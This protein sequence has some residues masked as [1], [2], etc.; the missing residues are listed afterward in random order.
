MGRVTAPRAEGYSHKSLS[1]K[2]G[3]KPGH[4]IHVVNAPRDLDS[5]Y[6]PLPD[7]VAWTGANARRLDIVHLFTQSRSE[8]QRQLPRALR[9]I[10]QDGVIWVS[11]PKKSSGVTTD[12]TEDVVRQVALPLLLVDVKV[13]AVDA[14]WSGL[15]LVVRKEH[16]R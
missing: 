11:W 9:R 7:G 15:K 2:L 16:R 8:L 14:I 4:R 13:C 6:A 10:R 5:L 1:A 12:V 3:I